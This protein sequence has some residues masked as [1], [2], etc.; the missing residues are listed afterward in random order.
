MRDDGDDAVLLCERD[1][2]GTAGR[3]LVVGVNDNVGQA[4][5][6]SGDRKYVSLDVDTSLLGSA[7]IRQFHLSEGWIGICGKRGAADGRRAGNG[8]TPSIAASPGE[9]APAVSVSG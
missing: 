4:V 9:I 7:G 8:L 2:G 1:G 5:R 3:T 6:S